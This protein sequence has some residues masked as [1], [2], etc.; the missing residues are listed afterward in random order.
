MVFNMRNFSLS[1][2]QSAIME[3]GQIEVLIEMFGTC[4]L[5]EPWHE[6]DRNRLNKMENAFYLLQEQFL[7]KKEKLEKVFHNRI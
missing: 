5:Q 4:L 3:L 2:E 6:V 1:E 7:F